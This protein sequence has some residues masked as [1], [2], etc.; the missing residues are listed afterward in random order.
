[1]LNHVKPREQDLQWSGPAELHK[2]PHKSI[3]GILADQIHCV[4]CTILIN[5]LL[6][7][8]CDT[9][10]FQDFVRNHVNQSNSYRPITFRKITV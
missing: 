6:L 5:F 1:M 3:Q 9:D 2:V 7:R 8:K 10:Y 4:K